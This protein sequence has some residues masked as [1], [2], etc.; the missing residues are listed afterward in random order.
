LSV[1]Q[2]EALGEAL[3]D[4]TTPAAL[5]VWLQAHPQPPGT[6]GPRTH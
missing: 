1:E 5:D 4:F 2:L 3:L 6:D